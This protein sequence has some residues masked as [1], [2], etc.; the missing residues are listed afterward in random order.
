M[1]RR[2]IPTPR[3]RQ[4]TYIEKESDRREDQGRHCYLGNRIYSILQYAALER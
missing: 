3:A 4:A 2:T 1:R